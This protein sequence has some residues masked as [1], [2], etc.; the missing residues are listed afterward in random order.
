MRVHASDCA[1]HN[2]PAKMPM[3]CDCGVAK[4]D[5]ETAR[6]TGRFGYILGAALRNSVELW[7]MRWLY[8]DEKL[9]S[10][11]H[12]LLTTATRLMSGRRQGHNQPDGAR[13]S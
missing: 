8:V 12:F 13:R 4:A 1:L 5:K 2:L 6:L 7:K 11:V 9:G 3:A 10:P